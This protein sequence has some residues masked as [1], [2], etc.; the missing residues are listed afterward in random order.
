[1]VAQLY[2]HD[3]VTRSA[4]RIVNT[5]AWRCVPNPRPSVD[6]AC[7]VFWAAVAGWGL[8]VAAGVVWALERWAR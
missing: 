4:Q 7:A 1:M 8:V 2:P 3:T 5:A 6:W